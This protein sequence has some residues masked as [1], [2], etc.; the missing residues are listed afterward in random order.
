M[1]GQK[2]NDIREKERNNDFIKFRVAESTSDKVSKYQISKIFVVYYLR[3]CSR[4]FHCN[5]ILRFT[6]DFSNKKDIIAPP[7]NS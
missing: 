6:F 3:L 1:K 2:M 5:L 7:Q 4:I